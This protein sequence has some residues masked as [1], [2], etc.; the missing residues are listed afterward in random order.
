VVGYASSGAHHS[1]GRSRRHSTCRHCHSGGST[2]LRILCG[3]LTP[4]F[5][6]SASTTR[7]RPIRTAVRVT[8][9]VLPRLCSDRVRVRSAVARKPWLGVRPT[10]QSK[11][12]SDLPIAPASQFDVERKTEYG[13]IC[14]APARLRPRRLLAR[15]ARPRPGQLCRSLAAPAALTAR[16]RHTD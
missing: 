13:V 9:S 14:G 3:H 8:G 7:D 16:G 1:A 4:T 6:L 11:W 12:R 10:L 2:P 5:S 15:A